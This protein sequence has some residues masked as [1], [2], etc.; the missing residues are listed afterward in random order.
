MVMPCDTLLKMVTIRGASAMQ[1]RQEI[2]TLE[3][4]KKTDIISLKID[5]PHLA[6]TADLVKTFVTAAGVGDVQDFVIN[7]KL[8][9]EGRHVL[10]ITGPVKRKS[11]SKQETDDR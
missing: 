5:V 9:M 1:R 11:L 4:G 7:G 2:G 3:T 6:P 10:T 8:V